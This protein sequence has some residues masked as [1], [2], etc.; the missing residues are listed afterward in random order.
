M[1]IN[2]QARVNILIVEDHALLIEGIKNLLG[3]FP[4]YHVVGE[5]EDGLDV[6]RACQ[7]HHP[8]LVLLDLGLP[9]MDGIDIIRQLRKRWPD[10]LIVVI[11]A[12][13]AEHKA[14]DALQAGAQGY[15][16]KKSSQQILLAALQT[17]LLGKEFIDPALNESQVRKQ[18]D[19]GENTV[20]TSRERQVLKLI[21]E[22]CRNR[23]VAEH[24]SIS[25]KTVETHRLNLMRKLDAHNSTE[26]VGWAQ[27]IGLIE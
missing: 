15:V 9:G 16:L 12:N 22:G 20:L 4:Q 2:P 17:V 5:V 18:T 1:Q 24:L 3:N 6:Y 21:A 13:A 8:D 27:R 10:L 26:L 25:L 19:H 7:T 23:D 11:T 14:S